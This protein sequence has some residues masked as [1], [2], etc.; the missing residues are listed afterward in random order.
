MEEDV[1]LSIQGE[2]AVIISNLEDKRFDCEEGS[3]DKTELQQLECKLEHMDIEDEEIKAL[4]QKKV[5]DLTR[6]YDSMVFEKEEKLA[7]TLAELEKLTSQ[8]SEANNKETVLNSAIVK[9]KEDLN[10]IRDENIN[11]KEATHL[12]DKIIPEWSDIVKPFPDDAIFWNAI[13]TCA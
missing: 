8:L 10:F 9:L 11:S 1:D 6:N 12:K 5:N 3:D 7:G 4:F 2:T 13:W